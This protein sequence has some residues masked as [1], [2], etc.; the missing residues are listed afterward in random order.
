[1]GN[2]LKAVAEE[3]GWDGFQP[4]AEPKQLS[5]DESRGRCLKSPERQQAT[6][7]G[8]QNDCNDYWAH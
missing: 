4:T 5:P 1:M 3:N 8:W 6:D 7:P 2:I